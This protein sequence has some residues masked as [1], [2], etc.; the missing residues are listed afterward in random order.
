MVAFLSEKERVKAAHSMEQEMGVGILRACGCCGCMG[1]IFV[2]F[3]FVMR[4]LLFFLA[5]YGDNIEN[6]EARLLKVNLTVELEM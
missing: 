3:L 1:L 6:K 2:W 5:L 4:V